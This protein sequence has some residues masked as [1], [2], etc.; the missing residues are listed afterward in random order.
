MKNTIL[1]FAIMLSSLFSKAQIISNY[2]ALADIY[3][4]SE[5]IFEGNRI[6]KNPSFYDKK[7]QMFT[8]YEVKV[9]KTIL[10]TTIN[11]IIRV[12]LEGGA[13]GLEESISSH[14]FKDIPLNKTI[15]FLRKNE[16]GN[17][18][19]NFMCDIS[20]P[21]N[22]IGYVSIGNTPYTKLETF[23][24]DLSKISGQQLIIEKKSLS[25][26][27]NELEKPNSSIQIP[28]ISYQERSDNF[29][30]RVQRYI[31]LKNNVNRTSQVTASDVTL[32]IINGVITGTS[33]K[34]YEFDVNI[35]SNNSS[36]Y[37]ENIP[38]WITYNTAVFGT[39]VVATSSVIVTNGTSF[40]N[41]N[42]S[43]A[44]TSIADNSSN[45]F[46]FALGTDFTLS[47]PNRVNIT[48]TYKQ[49]AHVK[50]LIT[51]CG[52]VTVDLSNASTAINSAYYTPT[53]NGSFSTALNYTALNY[54]GSLTN[55]IPCLPTIL[56]FTSPINGGVS[57][58][59]T[60]A[61]YGFGTTR[62]NGQVK[63]RNA[64]DF[65]F[66]YIDK[67]NTFDYLSWTDTEIKIKMPS[68]VDTIGGSNFN[69]PGTGRF[70]VITNANDSTLSPPVNQL[71][72]PFSVYYSLLCPRPSY[73][74]TAI[75]TA[76]KLKANLY[77]SVPSTGGYVIRLDT[78]ISNHPDRKGC[79]IKAVKSWVCLTTVNIKIGTDTIMQTS[80]RD[81]I[82]NLFFAPSSSFPFSNT[83]ADTKCQVSICPSTTPI[84]Y[85]ND[86][87]IKVNNSKSFFYDTTGATLPSGKID[88]Y[89][90]MLHEI[91]HG[92][93]LMHVIDSSAVMYY[94]TLGNQP[95]S[96]SG[97][98]RRTLIPSTT[99]I[100]G[101]DIQVA[102]SLNN[103]TGACGIQDM[104]QISAGSC[105]G[106]S[107][108]IESLLNSNFNII[109]YPNPS[110]DGEINISFDA[111]EN[112]KPKLELYNLL[113]EIVIQETIS[114]NTNSKHFITK[115]NLNELSNGIYIL[116]LVIG[117][118]KASYKI[119][120]Q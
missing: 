29:N 106:G 87:D 11:Q 51:G 108:G 101:G 65:G 23:Y 42:Y 55:S 82:C 41:V 32:Q 37:L 56:D 2:S 40:N 54:N 102:S 97:S 30:N 73:F 1:L 118:N 58:I 99:D 94:R 46:A 18:V 4:N 47:N 13:I 85:I 20:N 8:T 5:I 7:R 111:V 19:V 61:G 70:K 62:G 113:G 33:P 100:D 84:R 76:Q 36:S 98:S 105:T 68:I 103:I 78:S 57:D 16:R 116:N 63:F 34:Y 39:S 17:Y 66:P 22:I 60:I 25:V 117:K 49:L 69:T 6:K 28:T 48:T 86:F 120:K 53:I 9:S 12:E 80:A 10:N 75:T 114:N 27:V 44:N 96:I 24:S 89:E 14:G 43:P 21:E 79:V 115:M 81:Q 92:I 104:I 83:V 71:S 67:L 15:F 31:A 93:G 35:K 26:K 110:T 3:K 109:V 77:K 50:M 90:V 107:A 74:Q 52:N 119:V 72:Q 95:F 112:A 91:G 64:D 59:L 38:V 45:T 88:F